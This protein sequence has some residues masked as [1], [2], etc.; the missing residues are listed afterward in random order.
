[1]EILRRAKV[2]EGR[3]FVVESH[4]GRRTQ[5]SSGR[6]SFFVLCKRKS[7]I[8]ILILLC[9]YSCNYE[10]RWIVHTVLQPWDECIK[11]D[12]PFCDLDVLKTLS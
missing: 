6:L 5:V 2:V 11:D 10:H 12:V 4:G 1:M 8:C 7:Y 3:M 9:S